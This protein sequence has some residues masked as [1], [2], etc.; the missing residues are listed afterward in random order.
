MGLTADG[1]RPLKAMLCVSEDA[2]ALRLAD[3]KPTIAWVDTCY[4]ASKG[5]VQIFVTA[6]GRTFA[7]CFY[8]NLPVIQFT[9][10]CYHLIACKVYLL[11]MA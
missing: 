6:L 8:Q 4:S 1:R 7:Y 9:V 5:H 2:V 10:G 11:R 3:W